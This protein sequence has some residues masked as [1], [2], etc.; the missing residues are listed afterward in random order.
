MSHDVIVL[1]AGINGL[2][3]SCLLAKKKNKVLCLEKNN[4]VGGLAS[5][6]QL[7]TEFDTVPFFND[8]SLLNRRIA[9][10]LQLS[11]YGLEFEDKLSDPGIYFAKH[12]TRGITWSTD[13]QVTYEDIKSNVSAKE[14]DAFLEFSKF[15]DEVKPFIK[16]ICKD[17]LPDL[18]NLNLSTMWKVGVKAAKLRLMGKKPMTNL[19]RS[20][21]MCIADLLNEYFEDETLKASLSLLA[22]KGNYLAPWSPGTAANLLLWLGR[23]DYPVK[24]GAPALLNAL[25][26]CAKELGVTIQTQSEVK[27][28]VVK[29]HS[30]SEIKITNGQTLQASKVYSTLDPHTTFQ[31]LI[32][33]QEL[34]TNFKKHLSHIR[35]RGTVAQVN[36]T[37]E[38]RPT[39][40]SDSHKTPNHV[41]IAKSLD[42]VEQ[43]FDPV[44]YNEFSTKPSLEIFL[45]ENSSKKVTM[46]ILTNYVP[47][48]TKEAWSDGTRAALKDV[49]CQVLSDYFDG[50]EPINFSVITPADLEIKYSL[51]GGHIFHGEQTLDQMICRPTPETSHYKTP[52]NNLFLSGNACHPTGRNSGDQCLLSI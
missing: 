31:K 47:Y 42:A 4:Y 51:T 38:K 22:V 26:E 37:F 36:L 45:K 18:Q 44:K 28:L 32:K 27:E 33:P 43:S 16:A 49:V 35:Y 46:S 7:S 19:L 41:V 40:K 5:T 9:S 39:L 12:N 24:G 14:A 8:T 50:V 23:C 17:P 30:I 20:T 52:I 34:S 21:P 15:L 25:V 10:Q 6:Q 1:G 2:M 11:K 13:P 3:T 48:N 29:N